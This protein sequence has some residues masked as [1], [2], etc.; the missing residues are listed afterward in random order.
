MIKPIILFATLIV[1]I[2]TMNAQ[3]G[4][5]VAVMDQATGKPKAN[6]E[7]S[8]QVELMNNDGGV[9]ASTV[10]TATTNDFGVVSVQVGS[11]STFDN[12]DWSKLP[13]WVSAT[14]DGVNVGKTQVLTVPVAEYTKHYG[15]LTPQ[16]LSSKKWTMSDGYGGAGSLTFTSNG[17]MTRTYSSEGGTESVSGSYEIVGD[18][19]IQRYSGEANNGAAYIYMPER[20]AIFA[21]YEAYFYK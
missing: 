12:I 17:N 14:V 20:N 7:V 1:S 15:K 4:Y 13:L 19:I 6:K 21:I 18:M 3:I 2:M 8:V 16:L 9:V 5:Q 11:S 10:Q